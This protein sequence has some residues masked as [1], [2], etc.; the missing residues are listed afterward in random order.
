MR[1][2]ICKTIYNTF[3]TLWNQKETSEKKKMPIKTSILSNLDK[4]MRK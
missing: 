2:I 4:K 1:A 3:Y